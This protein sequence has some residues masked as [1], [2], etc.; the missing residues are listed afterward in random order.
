MLCTEGLSLAEG[1]LTAALVVSGTDTRAAVV[2]LDDDQC[3]ANECDK[4]LLRSI[5]QG[6]AF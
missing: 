5:A 2:I 4:P 6:R 3:M 1:T